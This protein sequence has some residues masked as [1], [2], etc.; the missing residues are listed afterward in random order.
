MAFDAQGQP[1]KRVWDEYLAVEKRVYENILREKTTR[2]EGTVAEL[3]EKFGFSNAQMCAFLDGIHEAV[4]GVP[5]IEEIE[6]TTE[7][8][9]DIAYERLYKKMVD[10][11]AEALYT[12]PEWD[13]IYTAEQRKQFYTEQK[14]SHT[15]VRNEAKIGRNDPCPCGSGKKY[16]KCCGAAV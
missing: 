5:E 14:K 8:A 7:I 6:E 13:D 12:L 10:Y 2:V 15:V 11:K 9:F 3:A 16:K 4:D 1:V